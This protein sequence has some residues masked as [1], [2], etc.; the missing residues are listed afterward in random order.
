MS[1]PIVSIIVPCRNEVKFIAKFLDSLLANDY[2]KTDLEVLIVD[3]MSN[4]GTREIIERYMERY[5]FIRLLD[6]IK[7]ITP[8]ALNL[9]ILSAQGEIIMRMDVHAEYPTNY[10]SGLVSA[11]IETHADNV[12]GVCITVAD[13]NTAFAQAIAMAMAHPFGVGNAHFRIGVTE[14]RWVDTVPF[15]CYRKAVFDRIGLFDEEL[16][17]NQDDEFNLRLLKQGGRILLLPDI[18]TNYYARSSLRK[19]WKMYFQYGYFKPLVLRKIGKVMTAR[20]LVPGALVLS[21]A[22]FAVLAPWSELALQLGAFILTLYVAANITATLITV[23]RTRK[24]A[25]WLLPL[26]FPVLHFSYGF[27]FLR[28]ISRFL[29]FREFTPIG[30]EL[31]VDL[32]R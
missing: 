6:N 9:G 24:A 23:I 12:G 15:G 2:V 8:I 29:L 17:R 22:L 20:Q 31:N 32:S 18:V 26:I 10:V 25:A 28:G 4:D 1:T 27:G 13:K 7:Q 3:G 30:T 19:L 14:R 5:P 21:L 11:L 16:I